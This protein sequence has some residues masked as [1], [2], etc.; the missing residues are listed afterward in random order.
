MV[1]P[2]RQESDARSGWIAS[3]NVRMV[4]IGLVL[5]IIGLVAGAVLHA[6]GPVST[7]E[8]ALAESM[9][10]DR[11]A[12]MGSVGTAVDFVFGPTVAP[13]LAVLIGVL[14][15]RRDR[16]M[17]VL[18][19]VMIGLGWTSIDVGKIAFPRARPPMDLVHALVVET[20][21]SFP[22][23]HTAFAAALVAT[24]VVVARVWGRSPRWVLLLGV[25]LVVLV[26]VSRLWVGAHYL[27]DVLAAPFYSVATILVLCGVGS[28]V[29]P[30]LRARLTPST[31]VPQT[32]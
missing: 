7:H 5:G 31:S 16:A 26:A 22:S 11:P 28:L 19:P 24:L 27:G 6:T 23:G 12:W 14:L 3:I 21:A 2:P 20:D 25:P 10:S 29:V 18:A 13:L 15:W 9:G 8:L 30:W 17:A 1:A 32:P 4:V